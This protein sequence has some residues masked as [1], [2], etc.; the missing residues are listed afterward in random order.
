MRTRKMCLGVN[1]KERQG[2]EWHGRKVGKVTRNNNGV[3]ANSDVNL[4]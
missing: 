1:A 3:N 2:N 4:N